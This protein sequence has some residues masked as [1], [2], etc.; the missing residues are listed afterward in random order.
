MGWLTF[1]SMF[2]CDLFKHSSYYFEEIV[3][4]NDTCQDGIC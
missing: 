4:G 2:P 1:N 3:P